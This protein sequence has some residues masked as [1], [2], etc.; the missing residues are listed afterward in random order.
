MKL[1]TAFSKIYY[2]VGHQIALQKEGGELYFMANCIWDIFT[3][4]MEN[5]GTLHSTS[6]LWKFY[7]ELVG[8]TQMDERRPERFTL[9]L[10]LFSLL[11]RVCQ[12]YRSS[13]CM[14][15]NTK[16]LNLINNREINKNDVQKL[17][18]IVPKLPRNGLVDDKKHKQ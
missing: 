18:K 16:T 4:T 9:F 14:L 3:T 13:K 7:I 15:I 10:N 1:D 11:L 12:M 17:R 6:S 2:I 5:T 8:V